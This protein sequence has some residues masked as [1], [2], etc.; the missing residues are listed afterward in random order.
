MLMHFSCILTFTYLYFDID[1]CWCFSAH[2]FLP[3]FLLVNCS[4]A[5]KWKSTQ[6]QN[7]LC[8][9]ASSSS[10]TDSTPSSVRFHDDKA[11]KEFSENFSRLSIRLECQV[12]LSDFFDTDLPTVIY[13]R[14]W[15]SLCGIPATC[16]SLIIQEFYSNM[17]RFDT[18][19]P[20][21]VTHV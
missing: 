12:I 20:Q 17:H 5:L 6:P 11:R 4:M 14:G 18:S 7:P 15:K 19:V 16:P 9:G 10:L 21:F 8:S 1:L 2:F 13:S 3:F